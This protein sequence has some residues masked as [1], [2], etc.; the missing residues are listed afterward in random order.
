MIKLVAENW[1]LEGAEGWR[2]QEEEGSTGKAHAAADWQRAREF[3]GKGLEVVEWGWG[4]VLGPDTERRG[5]LGARFG[6]GSPGRAFPA[7]PWGLA[8]RRPDTSFLWFTSPY[9]TMKFILW[10]RFRC[11]II[12]FIILFVLLLFVGIFLYSFPV[13]RPDGKVHTP[14]QSSIWSSEGH[15][16]P[17]LETPSLVET[18]SSSM[19]EVLPFIRVWGVGRV[20]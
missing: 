7:D 2:S 8:S 15:G 17:H 14:F 20:Y 18:R 10:R 11:A 19:D 12:L 4:Q 13:S 6:E 5:S 3:R 1:V 16:A 9:K